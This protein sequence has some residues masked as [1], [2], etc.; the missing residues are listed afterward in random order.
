MMKARRGKRDGVEV[1]RVTDFKGSSALEELIKSCPGSYL[2]KRELLEV[3]FRESAEFEAAK[4][5]R[6]DQFQFEVVDV[7][8]SESF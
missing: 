8:P 2:A 7:V 1:I 3:T 6:L 5:D 4:A